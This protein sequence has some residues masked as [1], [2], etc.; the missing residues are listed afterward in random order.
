MV[1]PWR[2]ASATDFNRWAFC[3]DASVVYTLR[4]SDCDMPN[5][6]AMTDGLMPAL[7]AARTALTCPLVKE[8]VATSTCGPWDD[9]SVRGDRC[10]SD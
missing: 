5:C 9:L 2:R 4:T 3:P 8:S 7:A 1:A 6:R 10:R